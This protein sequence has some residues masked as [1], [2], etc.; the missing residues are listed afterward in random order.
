M[1]SSFQGG[2]YPVLETVKRR[3]FIFD[4]SLTI[5]LGLILLLGCL[6]VSSAAWNF[7]GRF[8]GHLR[9]IAVGIVVM[10]IAAMIPP[11]KLMRFAVPIYVVGLSLL[12]GVALF[13]LI[14]NGARR[15]LN[16]GVIIQPSEIMKLALPLTLAWYFQKREGMIRWRDFLMAGL[17][18]AMPVGLI[19]RQPDL[20][21]AMM[22]LLG[23]GALL[24][25]AG[26]RLWV[27]LAAIVSAVGCM[28]FAWSFM[29]EY[30]RKRVLTF[31]DPDRDPL[32]LTLDGR[33]HLAILAQHHLDDVVRRHLVDPQ[34]G[35]VD[36]LGG[37]RL[38]FRTH[39]HAATILLFPGSSVWRIASRPSRTP[40]CRISPSSVDSP[41]TRSRATPA[42]SSRSRPMW[43][44][45]P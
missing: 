32:S 16:V 1:M 43:P 36:G 25:V 23:G 22:V 24:F 10:W 14:K 35:G 44:R 5:I 38:P 18:L 19:M 31:L 9:N 37:Q 2:R 33:E 13:G 3:F 45:T 28:P 29:H 41:E 12:V 27:F 39:G 17:L 42:T 26:V 8:E 40:T 20:G 21:T 34:R 11:Q 6:A 7:P 15:W 4:R 30:Q